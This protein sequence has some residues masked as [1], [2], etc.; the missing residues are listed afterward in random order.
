[1]PIE[2]Q[3]SITELITICQSLIDAGELGL[4]SQKAARRLNWDA[5]KEIL[6]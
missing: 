1:M 2:E 3:P 5:S 6:F 4:A